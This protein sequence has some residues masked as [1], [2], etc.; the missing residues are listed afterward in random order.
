MLAALAGLATMITIVAIAILVFLNPVY[1]AFGQDRAGAAAL[2][3]FDEVTVHSSK[4]YRIDK[5]SV[6]HSRGAR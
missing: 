2:T 5:T 3:G 6:K 4:A 1:V